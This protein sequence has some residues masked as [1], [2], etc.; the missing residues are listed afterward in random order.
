MEFLL[1]LDVDDL[2][3]AVRFYRDALGLKPGRR[4]GALGVEMLGGPAPIYLLAKAS[5]TLPASEVRQPRTYQ[6]HWTPL[7]LDFVV[8]EIDSAVARALVAGA[9]LEQPV[10]EHE[11]G[12]LALLADP[13]GHGFCF[14]QFLGRGY[15]AIAE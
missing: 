2:D 5:G 11:W 13:F 14:V 8:D 4:L 12:K 6:R 3:E 15:D 9:R 1:N 10:A 7:H